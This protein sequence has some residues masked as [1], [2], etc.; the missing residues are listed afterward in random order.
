MCAKAIHHAG[1]V[2]VYSPHGIDSD[3]RDGLDYLA[4]NKVSLESTDTLTE[5]D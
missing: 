3:H 1:I 4:E 2:T 5:E